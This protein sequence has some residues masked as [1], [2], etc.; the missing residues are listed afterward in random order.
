LADHLIAAAALG[1]VEARVS[2]LQKQSR[3]IVRPQRGD[4]TRY[5]DAPDVLASRT[6]LE[7]LIITARRI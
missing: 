4:A 2:A 1:S 6:F 5:R 3:I 7:A